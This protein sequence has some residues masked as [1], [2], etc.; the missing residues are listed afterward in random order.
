MYYL[1]R[2]LA[3]CPCMAILTITMA[4]GCGT[5]A[6]SASVASAGPVSRRDDARRLF[7][8][9]R[10]AAQAGD[11]I[12]SEQYLSLAIDAGFDQRKALPLLLRVCLQ[13]SRL[14]SA[15][16][17]AEP[18]L[19]QHPDDRALRYLVATIHL[20]LGQVDAAR[21]NLEELLRTDPNNADAHYLLG[22]VDMEALPNDSVRDFQTYLA[23]APQ[24]A[25]AF[26]VKSRL[27]ELQVSADRISPVTVPPR[28][29]PSN[30]SLRHD[31]S[32]ETGEAKP[33]DR[34]TDANDTNWIPA[35]PSHLKADRQ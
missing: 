32:E 5:G 28:S 19:L 23:L 12:R 25:R 15:L 24:G 11:S 18:Y 20:S 13:D 33:D 4:F 3:K 8:L 35:T 10:Q 6:V 31:A 22:I 16:D 26:E 17:H 14:R 29:D 34:S 9:G 27:M 7:E 21:L 30:G 1:N 2:I